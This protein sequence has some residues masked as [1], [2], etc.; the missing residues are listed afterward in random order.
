MARQRRHRRLNLGLRSGR[1]NLWAAH[2]T[3]GRSW[4]SVGASPADCC[5][6]RLCL[7][8]RET[9]RKTVAGLIIGFAGIGLLLRPG[10]GFDL[11]GVTMICGGQIAPGPPVLNS[12]LGWG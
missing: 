8:Q 12:R 10:S 4:S 9:P 5:G 6:Y 3:V 2:R 1:R 11:F 7:L